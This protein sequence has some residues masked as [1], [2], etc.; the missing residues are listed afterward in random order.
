MSV[1]LVHTDDPDTSYAAEASLNSSAVEQLKAII[2]DE[3]GKKPQA[4]FEL[5]KRYFKFR[6]AFNWPDCKT[7]SVAKRLSELHKAGRVVD[8]GKRVI[9]PYKKPVAVWAVAK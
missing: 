2:L 9:G 6:N 5:T 8:T 4:V 3:L 7:D 1:A